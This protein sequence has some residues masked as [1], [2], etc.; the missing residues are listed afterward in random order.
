[1]IVSINQP[2]YLPWLG[3]FDR[4]DASDIHIVLNH[5]QFEK[6]SFT[7]RNKIKTAQGATWLTVPLLTKGKFGGLAIQTIEIDNKSKWT[8]KHLTSI[9]QNYRKTPFFENYFSEL[10][11]IYKQEWAN[12]N[13][14]V[15]KLNTLFL[16]WLKIDTKIIYSSDLKINSTKSKL[17]LDLCK[18]MKTTKYISGAV[19]KDYLETEVFIQN[20]IEVVFQ[21]YQHPIYNQLYQ[22]KSSFEPYMSIL[23]LL[24]NH[25]E[26][27][28]EIIKQ[29]R[30]FIK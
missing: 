7:N 1:M 18:K 2:A 6:N 29:G 25:G 22:S 3:Y 13:Q 12:L 10:E 27:S 19:G 20:Q 30:N 5:V 24:F 11:K 15:S 23:D 21:N 9:H 14:L 4:I 16:E 8:K 28:L 26:N 17:V